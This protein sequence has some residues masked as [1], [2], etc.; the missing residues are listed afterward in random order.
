MFNSKTRQKNTPAA[1][2]IAVWQP[3]FLIIISQFHTC[4]PARISVCVP[5]IV[6]SVVKVSARHDFSVTVSRS[7]LSYPMCEIKKDTQEHYRRY[8]INVDSPLSGKTG[9]ER[10]LIPTPSATDGRWRSDWHRRSSEKRIDSMW[11][12]REETRASFLLRSWT[13]NHQSYQ[14]TQSECG[15]ETKVFAYLRYCTNDSAVAAGV[16]SKS[17]PA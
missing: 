16:V 4:Q 14:W 1:F 12:E 13:M 2:A 5:T 15:F 6:Q 7:S 3:A 9:G 10:K 11:G 17:F 8:A